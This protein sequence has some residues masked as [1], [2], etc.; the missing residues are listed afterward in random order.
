MEPAPPQVPSPIG[1]PKLP[2]PIGP[3]RCKV[4]KLPSSQPSSTFTCRITNPDPVEHEVK[5]LRDGMQVTTV[6]CAPGKDTDVE[7]QGSGMFEFLVGDC[8]IGYE[9]HLVPSPPPSPPSPQWYSTLMFHPG[10][11][12][13]AFELMQSAKPLDGVRVKMTPALD[14][15]VNDRQHQLEQQG[16]EATLAYAQARAEFGITC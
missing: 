3:P 7:L 11:G 6:R 4:V 15:A 13:N 9:M 16:I 14:G 2:S 8:T 1:R 12:R 5:V 10:N